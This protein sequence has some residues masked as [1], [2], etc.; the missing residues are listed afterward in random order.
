M[1]Y[2]VAIYEKNQ[3]FFATVP[4]LPSLTIVG[5]SMADVIKNARIVIIDYLQSLADSNQPLPQGNDINLHL[6][7]PE[8][9]GYIWAI[10]SL[11]SLR[12]AQKTVHYPL[13]LPKALLDG[14][15]RTLG[16][17]SYAQLD[18]SVDNSDGVQAFILAAIEDKL[19]NT[20]KKTT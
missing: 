18:N 7:N 10:I 5:E 11:D 1:F 4:D 3:Q 17:T 6:D 12:F 8:F 19:K 9:L 14:I 2:P 13:T 16:D 15:Y 20:T